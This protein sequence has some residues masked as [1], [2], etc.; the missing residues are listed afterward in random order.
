MSR[1]EALEILGLPKNSTIEEAHKQYRKL[2][3]KLHPDLN[4]D[5]NTTYMFRL[6]NEAYEF[7]NNNEETTKSGAASK[8]NDTKN[9]PHYSQK[10]GDEY[11]N[12]T[13]NH[14]ANQTSTRE[15]E[16]SSKDAKTEP[17][18]KNS[19]HSS[20]NGKKMLSNYIFGRLRILKF[21]VCILSLL[22]WIS[23]FVTQP[24]SSAD[25]LQK[26]VAIILPIIVILS[27]SNIIKK[28]FINKLRGNRQ[29][30]EF[31]I[32]WLVIQPILFFSIL[33]GL[34]VAFFYGIVANTQDKNTFLFE[35]FGFSLMAL[36]PVT[37]IIYFIADKVETK[38][39]DE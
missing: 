26:I 11:N 2:A 6:I 9:E 3:K 1:E 8:S 32:E 12:T 7:L 10:T 34:L 13:E 17:T 4:K 25:V 23:I 5:S 31:Q 33:Q 14:Y 29:L 39:I 15:S 27:T 30:T 28:R 37:A 35:W 24:E 38:E 20:F 19:T 21:S 16:K 22:T 18:A 36:L